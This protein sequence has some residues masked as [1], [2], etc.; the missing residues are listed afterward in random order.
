LSTRGQTPFQ[1]R[2]CKRLTLQQTK[3]MTL[4]SI[5][6]LLITRLLIVPFAVAFG[7]IGS[8]DNKSEMKVGCFSNVSVFPQKKPPVSIRGLLFNGYSRGRARFVE[9]Y[10][11]TDEG[12]WF[13]FCDSE[14]VPLERLLIPVSDILHSP[15]SRGFSIQRTFTGSAEGTPGTVVGTFHFVVSP[16]GTLALD[17]S[18]TR[19]V[20][21]LFRGIRETTETANALFQSCGR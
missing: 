3:T 18:I 16:D 9:I 17:Y 19:R 11:A 4:G 10:T 13:V 14:R 20:K 12:M 1:A 15:S 6:R 8:G 2:R 5:R 21:Y 7:S